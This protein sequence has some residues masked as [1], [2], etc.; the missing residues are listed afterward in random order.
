MLQTSCT[1]FPTGWRSR[2]RRAFPRKADLHPD[3]SNRKAQRRSL[4]ERTAVSNGKCLL[5]EGNEAGHDP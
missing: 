3:R 4:V 1:R 2:E 5:Q